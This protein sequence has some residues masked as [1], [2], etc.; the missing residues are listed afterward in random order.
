MPSILLPPYGTRRGSIQSWMGGPRHTM[1]K[2]ALGVP[3]KPFKLGWINWIRTLC[4]EVSNPSKMA[5]VASSF[6]GRG[7]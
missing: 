2:K 1:E 6:F 4:E 7:R 5:V 3:F